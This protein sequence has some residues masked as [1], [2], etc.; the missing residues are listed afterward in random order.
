MKA[1][2]TGLRKLYKQVGAGRKIAAL[3]RGITRQEVSRYIDGVL[4][5]LVK[6]QLVRVFNNVVHPVRRQGSRVERILN[7][8][9]LSD[10]PLVRKAL[11]L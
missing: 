3:H 5:L 2:I 4:D 9:T 10:D 1:L 11:Q 7:V 6:E 8:P